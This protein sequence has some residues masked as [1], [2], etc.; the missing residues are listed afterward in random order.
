M[1]ISDEKPF[2]VILESD[3]EYHE[4]ENDNFG[5]WPLP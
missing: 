4:L 1:R 2:K 3:A 5:L